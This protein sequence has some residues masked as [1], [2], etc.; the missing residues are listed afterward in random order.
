ML[1]KNTN[2]ACNI[3]YGDIGKL[4]I[5]IAIII[6]LL[7]IMVLLFI[8]Y[9]SSVLG[10]PD[11][12]G[13]NIVGKSGNKTRIIVLV[14]NNKYEH[15]LET[16]WGISI[17]I[18]KGSKAIL[19]DTGP[20]PEVLIHN[21]MKTGV[22]LSSTS[23]VVLSHEHGD[24]IGGISAL[25]SYAH[26]ITVYVPH[27]FPIR[28]IE[29]LRGKGY[30]VVIV[31]NTIEIMKNV[32]ILKPLYGPPWEQALILNTSKGLV[33]ITGCS[34]P[35]ILNIVVEAIREFNKTPYIVIGGFHL[36][37]SPLQQVEEIAD[38][39]VRLRV[40]KIYPLHCSGNRIRRY[41]AEKYPQYYG[42][43]G[44]GL[45]IELSN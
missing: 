38:Q 8:I 20:S 25:D 10:S 42:D 43:G 33:I 40:H 12:V 14:D 4:S 23:I 27:G 7:A 29:Q 39:L 26:K 18:E 31:N 6:I 2:N 13:E 34:H 45:V 37:G 22:N 15:E 30:N 19:F 11:T 35:G 32:Y 16:A 1:K 9:E 5:K 21:S 28:I 3:R 36:I 24:H 44:V 41:L 17:C